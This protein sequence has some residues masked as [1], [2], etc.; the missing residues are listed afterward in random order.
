MNADQIKKIKDL[1]ENAIKKAK[2]GLEREGTDTTTEEYQERI[3]NLKAS[4]L[5]KVGVTKE[6]YEL[7]ERFF[8]TELDLLRT[9]I[10]VGK[11]ETKKPKWSEMEEKPEIKP[12][13]QTQI[14]DLEFSQLKHYDE[15]HKTIVGN[16][17]RGRSCF[18]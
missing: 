13:Y 16:L 14:K 7:A 4:I 12:F 9:K 2:F 18:S 11:L 8:D 17:L 15:D 3:E 1:L 5:K 10:R 6:E